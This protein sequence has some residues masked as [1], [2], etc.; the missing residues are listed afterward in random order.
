M[1]TD[2]TDSTTAL[3]IDYTLPPVPDEGSNPGNY[4]ET[5][6]NILAG[7]HRR[8]IMA[9]V[10]SPMAQAATIVRDDCW[11]LHPDFLRYRHPWQP[12]NVHPLLPGRAV[13]ILPVG[14]TETDRI[15]HDRG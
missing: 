5:I 3:Y 2:L 9:T 11:W 4:V 13:T 10:S 12:G 6:W 8:T 14:Q 7:L 1:R 15:R